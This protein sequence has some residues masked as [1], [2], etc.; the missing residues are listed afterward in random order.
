MFENADLK[1]RIHLWS[2]IGIG[3]VMGEGVLSKSVE[4][5][6]LKELYEFHVLWNTFWK[7]LQWVSTPG[8]TSRIELHTRQQD[9]L[10]LLFFSIAKTLVKEMFVHI[11][12]LFMR[13]KLSISLALLQSSAS[14]PE[15]GLM[16]LTWGWN[17]LSN[18]LY[19]KCHRTSLL[20]AI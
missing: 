20:Q 16:F 8:Q 1:N 7:F 18:S 6:F 3:L 5:S 11:K 19:E 9:G 14:T 2:V 17:H 15:G 4:W 13:H 10:M 12:V